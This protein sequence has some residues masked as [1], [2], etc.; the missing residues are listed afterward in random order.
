MQIN[1]PFSVRVPSERADT[2]ARTDDDLKSGDSNMTRTTRL[3]S[4][5]LMGA[6][7]FASASA[8]WSQSGTDISKGDW[9]DY[10]GNMAAQRYSPLS[11]I[12]ADNVGSLQVAWR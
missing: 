8:A 11:Q 2:N 10:N 3:I 5:F 6:G 9:P 7:M 4:S 12:N 1:S